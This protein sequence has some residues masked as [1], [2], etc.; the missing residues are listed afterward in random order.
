MRSIHCMVSLVLRAI[1]VISAIVKIAV[2]LLAAL[3]GFVT[4]AAGLLTYRKRE[5]WTKPAYRWARDVARRRR[6]MPQ[7][8]AA[9]SREALAHGIT[10]LSLGGINC[11]LLEADDGFVLIDT[12][13]PSKR[14][15]LERRLE[16]AGCRPGN[17]KLI[18]LTHGDLD[19]AGNAAHLR[20]T[21]GTK[22][23]MHAGDAGM[24]ERGDM[25]WNRKAKP[26]RRTLTSHAILLASRLWL[27]FFKQGEFE[28]FTPD[29]YVGDDSE[30]AR[31]GLVGRVLS[32]PG[33]SKGSIGVLTSQGD[34]FCGDLLQNFGRPA[35]PFVD[36]LADQEASI[37]KLRALPL[38]TVYPGHGK[39]FAADRVLRSR[40]PGGTR[41]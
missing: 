35:A 14:A 33:H 27:L 41:C 13:L 25:T 18:V 31:Y 24:V 4:V 9:L 28:V 22:I 34:L 37:G 11:Y 6:A 29:M 38:T 2:V 5:E 23:V 19:H 40:P 32:L 17:L 36:D 20:G 10:I 12:G 7:S 15:N 30:L 16:G 3:V 26:D 21:Y 39:P 1:A 8:K